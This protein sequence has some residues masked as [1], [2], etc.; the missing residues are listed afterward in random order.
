[1]N[2]NTATPEQLERVPGLGK[3]KV[4]AIVAWRQ[5]HPFVVT[6]DVM[7]VKGF[8]QKTYEKLRGFLAVDGPPSV[9]T[10]PPAP[11]PVRRRDKVG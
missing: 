11:S 3:T 7:K 1:M 5:S 2:L 6:A 8:G 4:K 10:P 9:G